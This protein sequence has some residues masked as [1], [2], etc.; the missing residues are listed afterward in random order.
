MSRQ[1]VSRDDVAGAIIHLRAGGIYP[2]LRAIRAFIGAG[3]QTTIHNYLS[4]LL[5]VE[6]LNFRQ[7]QAS[8]YKNTE[9]SL[10]DRITPRGIL[11]SSGVMNEVGIALHELSEVFD[12]SYAIFIRAVNALSAAQEQ[13]KFDILRIEQLSSEKEQLVD[14]LRLLN[15]ND[16]LRKKSDR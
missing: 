11:D 8:G 13:I 14:R 12:D 15:L 10:H 16:G 7:G 3:S 4:E 1:K 2:S 6:D 5:A 9:D